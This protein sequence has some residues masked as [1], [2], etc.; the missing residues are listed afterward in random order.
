MKNHS[1]EELLKRY[2]N[3][4]LPELPGNFSQNVWREIR[5]RQSKSTFAMGIDDFLHWFLGNRSTLTVSTLALAV[6]MSVAWT[7]AENKPTPQERTQQAL[8]LGV[9]SHQASPLT[10]L[11]MTQ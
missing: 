7:I 5:L 1:L 9:F 8:G 11:A 4:T 3:A 6:V 10:R 2:G